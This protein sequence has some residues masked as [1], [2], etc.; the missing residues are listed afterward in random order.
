MIALGW[1]DELREA[2]GVLA[3]IEFARV[4]NHAGNR[5]SVASNPFCGRMSY[6]I[7]TMVDGAEVV[8]PSAE[9]VIDLSSSQPTG[10]TF[11][12]V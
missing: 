12:H 9:C 4:H 1:F 10:P 5:C 7:R 3:P 8:S 6:D 11:V 2:S